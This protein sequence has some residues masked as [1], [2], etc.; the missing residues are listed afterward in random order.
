M[1]VASTAIPAV[2]VTSLTIVATSPNSFHLSGLGEANQSYGIYVSTNVMLPMTNWWLLGSTN[3][4]VG[5]V[6]QFLSDHATNK[7]CFYRFGQ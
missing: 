5:G 6:I 7:Q 4:D 3:A 1:A 2:P